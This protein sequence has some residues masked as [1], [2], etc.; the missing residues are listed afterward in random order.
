MISI[1]ERLEEGREIIRQMVDEFF[2]NTRNDIYDMLCANDPDDYHGLDSDRDTEDEVETAI[3]FC[4]EVLSERDVNGKIPIHQ[5]GTFANGKK[6]NMKSASFIV[7]LALLEIEFHNEEDYDIE[8]GGLVDIDGYSILP[9]RV[10]SS[11]SILRY[12]EEHT[13]RVDDV[14]LTQLIRLRRFGLLKK[15]DIFDYELFLDLCRVKKYDINVERRFQFL[16]KWYP[17]L[18]LNTEGENG[19]LLLHIVAS[20]H[21]LTAFRILFEYGMSNYLNKRRSYPFVP[22]KQ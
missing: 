4:P 22:R 17:T 2:D 3:C 14:F 13:Q 6:C 10:Q 11:D 1:I 5:L 21:S 9:R 7:L 18:L 16:I 20:H 19:S 15:E 8:L 12:G